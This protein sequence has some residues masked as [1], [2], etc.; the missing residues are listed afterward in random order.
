[1]VVP[2][3]GEAAHLRLRLGLEQVQPALLPRGELEHHQLLE[4][5]APPREA[6]ANLAAE[7][8]DETRRAHLQA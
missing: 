1:M 2:V 8:V 6:A 3:V 4:R 7:L 5:L